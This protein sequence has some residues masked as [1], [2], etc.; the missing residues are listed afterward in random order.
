MFTIPAS[1]FVTPDISSDR[2]AQVLY[3]QGGGSKI[4]CNEVLPLTD[5]P[6]GG[7]IGFFE[8]GLLTGGVLLLTGM[9]G[10]ATLMAVYAVPVLKKRLL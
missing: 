9:I 7:S 10:T 4:V 3:S 8:Q 2:L 1:A 5:Q 6:Q